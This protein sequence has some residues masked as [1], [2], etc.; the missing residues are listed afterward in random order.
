MAILRKIDAA[1]DHRDEHRRRDEPE[2]M[3]E[4]QKI[5]SLLK[6]V[7]AAENQIQ[8]LEYWSD[9]NDIQNKGEYMGTVDEAQ[10]WKHGWQGSRSNQSENALET[11]GIRGEGALIDVKS[12][13][14]G[15]A[16]GKQPFGE[17]LVSEQLDQMHDAVNEDVKQ[18]DSVHAKLTSR[19]SASDFNLKASVAAEIQNIY[20]TEKENQPPATQY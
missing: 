19:S 12:S 17:P 20:K 1:S 2:Y 3:N 5:D 18:Y 13:R 4:K 7:E 9:I 10:G 16:K 15:I 6:A 14:S 11:P 8:Q